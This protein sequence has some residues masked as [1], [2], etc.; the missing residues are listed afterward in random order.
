MLGA[1]LTL[2]LGIIIILAI[3]A[4]NGY[5]VAQE[6]AYMSVDRSR[7][8]A[9]AE[10]GNGA[11][12]NAL[13]VTRKTSFMLSGAQLGIT[14][15]GLLIGFVAEPLVGNSLAVILGTVG[16]PSAVSIS[17]GTVLA[18]ALS[19]VV[20]MIF[21]E[22]YPKNLAIANPEP[23]ALGMA[24]STNIYL[25]I[26]GWL[27]TIFDHA[28]NGLLK[29]LKI[30]PVHD[31]DSSAT[32]RDLEHIVADSRESGDLPE[33]LSI[34]IDRI[35][36]FPE[37]DVEHAMVPRSRTDSIDPDMTIGEV[38]YLMS[39]AHTRYPVINDEDEPVGVVHLVDL[40]SASIDQSSPVSSIMQPPLVIPTLMTLPDARNRMTESGNDMACVI[41]EYGGFTGILTLEDLSEEVVG[42]IT[43]EHDEELPVF[44][45]AQS[46]DNWQMNGEVHIDEAERK[47]GYDLPRGDYE[48]VSGMLIAHLG[49]L[50]AVN[51]VIKI[52]LPDDP[53]DLVED[54]P[55]KRYIEATVLE[56]DKRVPTLVNL[57]LLEEDSKEVGGE[58]HV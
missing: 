26:F 19:T 54:E 18:L 8:S 23:L 43:D 17:V 27:I 29:L 1:V 5:F 16:I 45:E 7:L 22:L 42:E 57:I 48:T 44:F 12:K 15:T 6:F 40:L 25:A 34:M 24:R 30:E 39:K 56:I 35:L 47:I 58:Y 14:I 32:A 4:A 36:D 21:G 37:R 2:L 33:E 49:N 11:A 20:Q 52:E 38:R 55:V 9:L 50:P 53:A 31:V 28:A 3:I 41:D 51:E 13:S 10:E 46:D